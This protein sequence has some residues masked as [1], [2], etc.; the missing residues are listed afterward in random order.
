MGVA[1]VL[2][3]SGQVETAGR[4]PGRLDSV[5]FVVCVGGIIAEGGVFLG[6]VF[7]VEGVRAERVAVHGGRR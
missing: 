4:Y 2:V 6:G 7:L 5:A 1:G 3:S